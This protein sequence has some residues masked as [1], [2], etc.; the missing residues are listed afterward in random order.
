MSVVVVWRC[1]DCAAV[2]EVIATEPSQLLVQYLPAGWSL[3]KHD[4]S[5]HP[6][7]PH[8]VRCPACAGGVEQEISDSIEC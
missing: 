1:V 6:D 8:L 7:N 4:A 3:T 2:D 5:E